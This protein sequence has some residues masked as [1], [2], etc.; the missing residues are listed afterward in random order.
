MLTGSSASK[1]TAVEPPAAT[2]EPLLFLLPRSGFWRQWDHNSLTSFCG[3]TR[4]S[5]SCRDLMFLSCLGKLYLPYLLQTRS[6]PALLLIKNNGGVGTGTLAVSQG[7]TGRAGRWGMVSPTGR[8]HPAGCWHL[9]RLHTLL[10]G[11]T[12]NQRTRRSQSS[13]N[14]TP[15]LSDGC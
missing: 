10:K 6:S 3:Q 11:P 9:V 14:S 7:E 12:S 5:S 2:L 4:K 8:Q 1:V 13:C 15:W